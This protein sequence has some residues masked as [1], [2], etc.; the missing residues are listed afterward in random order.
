MFASIAGPVSLIIGGVVLSGAG[1]VCGFIA[2]RKLKFLATRETEVA[3]AAAQ[4]RR[5]CIASL[6]MC[7]IA[8]V[9]NAIFFYF[10]FTALLGMMEKRRVRRTGCRRRIKRCRHFDLG[11]VFALAHARNQKANQAHA[12]CAP[13][14]F[15]SRFGIFINN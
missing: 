3:K 10:N 2:W 8:F 9:I 11:I 15:A 4:L 14:V 12:R 7:G 13:G 1:L 6:V 5:P